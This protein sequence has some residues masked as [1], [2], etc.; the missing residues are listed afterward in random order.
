MPFTK[1]GAPPERPSTA[2]IA[3]GHCF[4]A[5]LPEPIEPNRPVEEPDH[6]FGSLLLTTADVVQALREQQTFTASQ[7]LDFDN[8]ING[9]ALQGEQ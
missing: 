5:S 9:S 6:P 2:E 1:N 8:S 7:N 3:F 4:R